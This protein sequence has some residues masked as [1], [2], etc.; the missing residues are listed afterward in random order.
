MCV[1]RLTFHGKWVKWRKSNPPA[2]P[3]VKKKK[4]RDQNRDQNR[5]KPGKTGKNRE[6]RAQLKKPGN[7]E[8]GKNRGKPGKT[9]STGPKTEKTGSNPGVLF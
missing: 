4:N 6:Y 2:L 7:R 9:G 5:E 3:G 1:F 8:T